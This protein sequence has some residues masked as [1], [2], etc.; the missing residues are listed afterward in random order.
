MVSSEIAVGNVIIEA[1]NRNITKITCDEFELIIDNINDYFKNEKSFCVWISFTDVKE[2]I[3]DY[4]YFATFN[5]QNTVEIKIDGDVKNTIRRLDR[6]FK[7]GTRYG[8][9][10]MLKQPIKDS[11]IT[12]SKYKLLGIEYIRV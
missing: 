6:Y 7:I 9:V 11:F 1:L 12:L 10:D 5:T 8:L 2:F 4:F 3:N